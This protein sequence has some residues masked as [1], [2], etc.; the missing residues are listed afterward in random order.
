[1]GKSARKGQ[2]GGRREGAGRPA[3]LADAVMLSLRVE[4]S[5]LRKLG[6]LAGEESISSYIRGVLRRH[7]KAKAGPRGTRG[8][9]KGL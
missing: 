7:V 8:G 9:R 4:S 2:R 3:E 5:L 6:D 1:M